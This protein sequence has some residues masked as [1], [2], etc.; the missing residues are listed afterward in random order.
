MSSGFVEGLPAEKVV[1]TAAPSSEGIK[2]N[3]F[4]EVMSD[5]DRGAINNW[6]SMAE[7][8]HNTGDLVALLEGL[9]KPYTHSTG[10]TLHAT[11]V[12]LFAAISVIRN[13]EAG[14]VA[15]PGFVTW[16]ENL[17]RILVE[18]LCSTLG[19]SLNKD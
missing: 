8:C 12:S 14:M 19:V 1:E 16:T 9:L 7:G 11:I 5:K 10:T 17:K 2:T 15:G 18:N 6:Y 3:E 4:S 13:S